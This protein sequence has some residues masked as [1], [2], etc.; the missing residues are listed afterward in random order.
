MYWGADTWNT[1]EVT[2]RVTH[3]HGLSPSAVYVEGTE[4]RSLATDL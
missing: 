1:V 3:R 2:D 4:L